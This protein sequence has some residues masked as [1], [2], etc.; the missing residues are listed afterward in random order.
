MTDERDA[1]AVETEAAH[2]LARQDGDGWNSTLQRELDAWLQADTRHRVAWLRLRAAW[3]RADG[4]AGHAPQRPAV[5]RRFLHPSMWQIAAGLLLAIGLGALLTMA[6]A[7][8]RGLEYATRVGENRIV[9]LGDGSRIT[10]N[11][12]TRLR[13]ARDGG[14]TVWLERGEAYFDIAHDPAHPFIVEAGGSRITVLGTR[15]TVRHDEKGTR[16]LVEQG[17]VR[18]SEGRASVELVRND[19]ATLRGGQIERSVHSDAQ[20]GQ[21]L[22]WREGRIVFDGTTLLD[23]AAEFN[24]YNERKLVVADPALGRLVIGGS[25][26]PGNVDGF[27][28]LLEQGFGLHA[29][30]RGKD[31]VLSR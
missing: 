22:A 24:R 23:A 31:I 21:R 17:R 25:F 7:G 9:A 3:H 11:T 2:W 1:Q 13:A 27:A 14:R 16:V 20:T 29:E 18:V 10:L 15:F 5:P 30:R 6:P 26:A 28:R 12:A 8:R 19:E 4:L